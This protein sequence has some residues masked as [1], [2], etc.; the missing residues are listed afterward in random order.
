[1]QIFTNAQNFAIGGTGILIVVAVA[2]E[3]INQLKA[4]II[5]RSYDEII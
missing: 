2:I 3:I 1:M 4:Q 5:T